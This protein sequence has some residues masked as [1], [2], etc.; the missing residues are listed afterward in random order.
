LQ[1][2]VTPGAASGANGVLKRLAGR[3]HFPAIVMA[4]MAA[5]V[6]RAFQFAAIAALPM[7]FDGQSLMAAPHAPAGRRRLTFRNSHGTRSLLSRAMRWNKGKPGR[8][9][10]RPGCGK[11][12]VAGAVDRLGDRS[13]S[14]ADAVPLGRAESVV[15]CFDDSP[16]D[17]LVLC[18]FGPQGKVEPQT[19]QMHAD[20]RRGVSGSGRDGQNTM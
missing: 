7:G 3:D 12:D 9:A 13:G 4:A 6:M 19:T 16:Q 20:V 17:G 8:L 11:A 1:T 5:D 18:G 15:G 2:E 14:L 10:D